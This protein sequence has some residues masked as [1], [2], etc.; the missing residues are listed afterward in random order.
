MRRLVALIVIVFAAVPAAWAQQ[1][2][3]CSRVLANGERTLCVEIVVQADVAEVWSLWAEPS[4]LQTWLAPIAAIDMREG[5]M[6]EASYD[7][8]QPLG[9]ERNILNRVVSVEPMRA[10]A[11]QVERAPPGFLHADEVGELVTVVALEP[12]GDGATRVRVSMHGFR[13]G[14][15]YDDLY[16]F[17]ARGNTWTLQKLGERIAAGPVD[18]ARP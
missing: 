4:Q 16:A 9:D 7:A 8:S 12:A 13:M 1:T 5:G 11:L 15:A 6:M 2:S 14:A 18:W 10:F 3:D 17:F